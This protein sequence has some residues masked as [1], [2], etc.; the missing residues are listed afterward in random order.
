MAAA[1]TARSRSCSSCGA[2]TAVHPLDRSEL[3]IG[4]VRFLGATLWSDLL[5]ADG[6]EQQAASRAEARRLV[7]DFSRIRRRADS[8]EIFT[9][10]A[11]ARFA[12]HAAWLQER[13]AHRHN[14]PTV[15]ITHH[16]STRRSIHPRF[17]DSLLNAAFVSDA[18]HLLHGERVALWIHGHTRDSFDRRVNSTRVLC[19]PRGYAKG[20]V[21]E[22][23]LFDP[24]LTV[25]VV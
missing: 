23:A 4:G 25:E 9:P 14:G 13:P 16:A 3:V 11:A 20:G 22:N 17:A 21:N 5:L 8:E 24:G 18:A 12:S 15:V 2:G 6:P 1:S 7:R 10:E 19:N